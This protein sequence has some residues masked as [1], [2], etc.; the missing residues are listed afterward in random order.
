[1][2]SSA[3]S[4]TFPL[5]TADFCAQVDG[6][7]THFAVT[8]YSNSVLALIT[9]TGTLGS[10]AEAQWDGPLPGGAP[11][12]AD[13]AVDADRPL[14][15]CFSVR[16]LLG[17]S[18]DALLHV[19]AQQVASHGIRRGGLHDRRF[20]VCLGLAKQRR[21]DAAHLRAL[22]DRAFESSIWG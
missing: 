15:G 12:R 10:I 17:A 20:I 8:I 3:S 9:Q 7:D 11:L 16:T 4:R 21:S 19:C 13:S 2:A 5:K 22:L 1:M 14:G 6:V 18:D